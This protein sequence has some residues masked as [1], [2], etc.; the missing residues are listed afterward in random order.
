MKLAASASE[1]GRSLLAPPGLAPERAHAL[2][3]AFE[4]MVRDAGFIAESQR[5]DLDVDPLPADEI[6]RIVLEDM[7]MSGDVVDGMRAITEPEK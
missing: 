2:R 4:Q 5:R 7:N 3:V 1:I 6:V